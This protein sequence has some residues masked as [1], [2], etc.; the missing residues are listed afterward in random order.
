MSHNDIDRRSLAMA[1]VI[2]NRLRENPG[3]LAVA[4]GNLDRWLSTC[5]PNCRA[6]LLEWKTILQNG[7]DSAVETLCSDDERSTRLRQSSPFAGEAFISRSERTDI[8]LRF[9]H[10]SP[11]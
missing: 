1:T 10:V 11:S 4:R 7:I 3:L 5:S 9:R 2:A 8:L 6:A